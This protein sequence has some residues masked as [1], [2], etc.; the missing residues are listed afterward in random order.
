[1]PL[2]DNQRLDSYLVKETGYLPHLK[3]AGNEVLK[4]SALLLPDDRLLVELV[5]RNHISYR[6]LAKIVR[7]SPG[8][9]W[10]RMRRL[11]NRLFSPLVIALTEPTTPLGDEYRQLAIEHFLQGRT[12]EELAAQHQMTRTQV[13]RAVAYVRGW[14]QGLVSRWRDSAR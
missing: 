4:R 6:Q 14:H 3:D 5:M 10:R 8:T 12:L 11:S 9:V 2:R 7:Q 1:M 13:R